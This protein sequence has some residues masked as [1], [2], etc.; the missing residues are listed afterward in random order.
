MSYPTLFVNNGIRY[1]AGLECETPIE[2]EDSFNSPDYG[3]GDTA[4]TVIFSTSTDTGSC[5]ITVKGRSE[6]LS[7]TLGQTGAAEDGD[8]EFS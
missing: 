6:K 3:P 4:R 5:L 8:G 7:R 2:C 1:S